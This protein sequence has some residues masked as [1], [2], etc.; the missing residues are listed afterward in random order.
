ML[1]T[2]L[3][4]VLNRKCK[5]CLVYTVLKWTLDICRWLQTTWHSVALFYQWVAGE[6]TVAFPHCSRCLSRPLS[7]SWRLPSPEVM[8]FYLEY[9]YNRFKSQKI[10]FSW[11]L[12]LDIFLSLGNSSYFLLQTKTNSICIFTKYSNILFKKYMY[13]GHNRFN[14]YHCI[15]KTIRYKD[16]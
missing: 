12:N 15:S 2:I 1:F 16:I 13:T 5:K 7:R 4:F 3:F 11:F 10:Q 6:W 9:S 8:F 14:I